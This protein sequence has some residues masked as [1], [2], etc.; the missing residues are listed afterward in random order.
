MSSPVYIVVG[1]SSGDILLFFC[2]F[3]LQTDDTTKIVTQVNQIDL[4]AIQL[5]TKCYVQ[6]E[7]IVAKI[8]YLYI[9][10]PDRQLIYR[11]QLKDTTVE[12]CL[13]IDSIG[14]KDKVVD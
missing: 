10:H 2:R 6:V 1:L 13:S 11:C 7:N 9:Q 12:E 8:V 4:T 14:V 3:D 5:N